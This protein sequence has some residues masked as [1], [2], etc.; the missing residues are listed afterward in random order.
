MP[1]LSRFL[2]EIFGV[3]LTLVCHRVLLGWFPG[4]RRWL[5]VSAWA[6][7]CGLLLNLPLVWQLLPPG[8]M[9][10]WSRAAAILWAILICGTTGALALSRVIGR[11]APPADLGRRG[12]LRAAQAAVV[13]APALALGY[14]TFVERRRLTPV[15]MGVFM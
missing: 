5:G 14:G 4:M 10:T 9:F 6:A 13:A 15:A 2:P 11:P 12:L 3:C 1:S 7:V 8:L